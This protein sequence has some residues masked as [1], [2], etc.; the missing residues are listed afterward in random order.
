MKDAAAAQLARVSAQYGGD[1]AGAA[2]QSQ[3]GAIRMSASKDRQE[4]ELRRMSLAQSGQQMELQRRSMDIQARQMGA[5]EKLASGQGGSGANTEYLPPEVR[6]R[7]VVLPNG[8]KALAR[9]KGDAAAVN[10][11]VGAT[12]RFQTALDKIEAFRKTHSGGKM[13][14]DSEA[15]QGKELRQEAIAALSEL[16]D[17]KLSGLSTQEQELFKARIP[18]PQEFLTTDSKVSAKIA[19]LKSLAQTRI[20]ESIRQHVQGRESAKAFTGGER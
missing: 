19:S 14:P 8:Q 6:E 13:L 4:A 7:V 9:D 10:T 2:A 1:K 18:D 3:I 11:A 5:I 20:S 17:T 15:D 16:Y 12:N